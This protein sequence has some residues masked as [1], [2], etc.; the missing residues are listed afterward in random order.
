M[1]GD[2]GNLLKNRGIC[3]ARQLAGSRPAEHG[4]RHSESARR[5]L[6]PLSRLLELVEEGE[7]LVIARHR[8]RWPN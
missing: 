2:T 1:L 8:S 6:R 4:Y 7:I 3:A 5:H